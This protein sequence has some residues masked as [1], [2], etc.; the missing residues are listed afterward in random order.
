[1]IRRGKITFVV[2]LGR[3]RRLIRNRGKLELKN[4][5]AKYQ[6][7]APTGKVAE[8][9]NVVLKVHYNVQPWVGILT[10]TPQVEFGRWKKVK[11]GVSKMFK[12]PALKVKKEEKKA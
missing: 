5:K 3:R 7:T 2:Y 4:Q 1:L 10:W 9:D 6:I 12:L 11:G 8:T